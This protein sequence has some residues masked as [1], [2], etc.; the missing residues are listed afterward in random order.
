MPIYYGKRSATLSALPITTI[1][2][3]KESVSNY[4]DIESKLPINKCVYNKLNF[5]V[6]G[7]NNKTRFGSILF[8]FYMM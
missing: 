5:T 7:N 8:E 3:L 2:S 6:F 1:E 4:A